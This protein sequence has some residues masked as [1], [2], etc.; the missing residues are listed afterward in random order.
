MAKGGNEWP[1]TT[2]NRWI[3]RLTT[4]RERWSITKGSNGLAKNQK[5]GMRL[6]K[7]RCFSAK[8]VVYDT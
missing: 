2:G 4:T 8:K 5:G 1:Q 6:V 7:N 3:E